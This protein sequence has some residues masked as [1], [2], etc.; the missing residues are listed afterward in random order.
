MTKHNIKLWLTAATRAL[1]AE[2]D[3]VRRETLAL[4]WIA[5]AKRLIATA[6]TTANTTTNTTTN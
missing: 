6:N 5:L 3:P 1:R 2:T 4:V